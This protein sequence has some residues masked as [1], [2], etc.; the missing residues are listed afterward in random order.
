MIIEPYSIRVTS[1]SGRYMDVFVNLLA[2]TVRQMEIIIKQYMPERVFE[3]EKRE[4]DD[5]I[6]T[7]CLQDQNKD[8]DESTDGEGTEKKH[9]KV[10]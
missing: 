3:S 8:D 1:I 10:Q 4:D 7:Y 6:G 9:G 2:V 5:Q